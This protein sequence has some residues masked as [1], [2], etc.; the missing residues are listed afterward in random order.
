[1]ATSIP[2]PFS[3]PITA[4][5]IE[6][7]LPHRYPFLLI[8]RILDLSGGSIES[9]V[10]RKATARKNVTFNEPF[11]TG[12]FPGHPIMPGVLIIEALAQTCAIAAFRPGHE[13]AD[14]RFYIAA[15]NNA[16]FR[17]PVTPGDTLELNV[18]CT[19]DRGSL[20]IFS[21]QAIVDGKIAAE[22]ELWAKIL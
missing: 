16:K 1:M 6:K 2:L 4:E 12:H 3:L 10:N 15:V 21:G 17:Q 7:I 14:S 20:I 13:T 18:E 9:R 5:N 22:A 8:D 19:K 11:F